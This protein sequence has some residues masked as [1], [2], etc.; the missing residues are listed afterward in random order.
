MKK[1]GADTGT[2]RKSLEERIADSPKV[3]G[4][5]Q[6]YMSSSLNGILKGAQREAA[7]MKDEYVGVEHLLI[8]LWQNRVS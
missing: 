2:V 1:V 5:S 3:Y 4:A 8:A 6:V 7:Q